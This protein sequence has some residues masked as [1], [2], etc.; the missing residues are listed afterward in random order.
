MYIYTC[1]SI[2]LY[3]MYVCVFYLVCVICIHSHY[4]PIVCSNANVCPFVCAVI[5]I[6]VYVCAVVIVFNKIIA[7]TYVYAHIKPYEDIDFYFYYNYCL[8]CLYVR[9]VAHFPLFFI[10]SHKRFYMRLYLCVPVCVCECLTYTTAA[11]S[12]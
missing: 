7:L 3:D 11:K 6:C 10:Y 1:A 12:V 5:Y 2:Y 8:R 4:L 9:P